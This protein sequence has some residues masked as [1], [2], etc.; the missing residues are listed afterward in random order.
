MTYTHTI[1]IDAGGTKIEGC[2]CF[3]TNGPCTIHF[4]DRVP[5]RF[6]RIWAR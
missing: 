4:K 2:M 3:N 6:I 1:E 5:V